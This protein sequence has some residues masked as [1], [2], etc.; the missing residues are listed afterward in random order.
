M[1]YNNYYIIIILQL[2]LDIIASVHVMKYMSDFIF[3]GHGT[4]SIPVQKTRL[5][6]LGDLW[7]L[8]Q[9]VIVCW[10]CILWDDF[11]KRIITNLDLFAFNFLNGG[12][13]FG[14]RLPNVFLYDECRSRLWS[15]A[16][17]RLFR[18]CK[19]K[20]DWLVALSKG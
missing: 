11:V 10:F 13:S 12:N 4:Y 16:F 3:T 20:F 14:P 18:C 17:P 8:L 6:G 1:V 15:A 5:I 9:T 2:N 7:V 19:S